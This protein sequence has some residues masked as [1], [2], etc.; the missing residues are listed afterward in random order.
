MLEVKGRGNE[1]KK[2]GE[3]EQQG[4]HLSCSKLINIFKR[5]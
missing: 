1:V 2:F 3:K 5:I 4:W